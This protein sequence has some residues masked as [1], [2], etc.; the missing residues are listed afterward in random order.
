MHRMDL[1]MD[2]EHI[3]KHFAAHI[4][5]HAAEHVPAHILRHSTEYFPAHT[6]QHPIEYFPSHI[7]R[8]STEYP[9]Y[10]AQISLLSTVLFY[11]VCVIRVHTNSICKYAHHGLRADERIPMRSRHHLKTRSYY[12]WHLFFDLANS[13]SCQ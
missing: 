10:S 1:E 8:H 2:C 12:I 5:R 11:G 3:G 4:L 6:L 13:S 7:Q 9:K